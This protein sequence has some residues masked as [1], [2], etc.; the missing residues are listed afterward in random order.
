MHNLAHPDGE[1]ATSR[2]AAKM[3]IA[4]GLSS[5]ATSSMEDVA[6][7]G[8]GNPY[9]MQLCVLRDRETTLQ[10]LKRAEGKY[11]SRLAGK[12][13]STNDL[14]LSIWIQGHLPVR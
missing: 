3:G 10:I 4:M 2:A 13:P 5:Y 11:C 12:A 8:L 1:I 9:A 6:A 14:S 7:E